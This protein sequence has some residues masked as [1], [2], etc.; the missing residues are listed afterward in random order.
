[1]SRENDGELVVLSR[2][3]QR[4]SVLNAMQCY[5]R[6]IPAYLSTCPDIS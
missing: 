3:C 1:M 2:G 4:W 6:Y 5:N